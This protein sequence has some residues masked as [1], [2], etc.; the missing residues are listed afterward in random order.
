MWQLEV[1]A[2]G[3]KALQMA[4]TREEAYR[5]VRMGE[6]EKE[7]QHQQEH[8]QR[9]VKSQRFT[10]Y[11]RHALLAFCVMLRRTG[12]AE[13]SCVAFSAE[14]VLRA[15]APPGCTQNSQIEC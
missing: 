2:H 14:A 8:P 12:C 4:D 6:E 15:Q 5:Q 13:V 9:D 7:I 11:A 10:G 3:S 1:Q